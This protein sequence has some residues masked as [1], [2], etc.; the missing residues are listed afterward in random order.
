MALLGTF[1]LAMFAIVFFRL[2][3]LQ[4][5]SGQKYL[6]QAKVNRV[7]DIAIPAPRGEI[8]DR[9]G[10]VLVSSKRAIAV[11]INPAE[12]PVPLQS[13]TT[14]EEARLVA[15]PPARD[16]AVYHRLARVLGMLRSA[17]QMLGR[18][19]SGPRGCRQI[20][21]AVARGFVQLSYANVT[22]ATDVPN[23]V[24]FYLEERQSHFPG[25]S[26]QQRLAAHL[27][28][29]HPG[30]AAVRDHRSAQPERAQ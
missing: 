3:F 19:A 10:N 11:Q 14:S 27:P 18:P 5:L 20:A 26:V 13:T 6:A 23:D 8:L 1:A 21:C 12:L 17:A 25:V 7:R 16:V 30:R 24:L 22:V 9:S 2:W 15:H 29:A 28:T 4:V